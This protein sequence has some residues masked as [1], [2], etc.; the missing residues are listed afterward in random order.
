MAVNNKA[1][2]ACAAAEFKPQRFENTFDSIIIP[3]PKTV[4]VRKITTRKIIITNKYFPI[5]LMIFI[6]I[7]FLFYI[8]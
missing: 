3:I 6:E 1:I 7:W 5:F 2:N 8:L 4:I